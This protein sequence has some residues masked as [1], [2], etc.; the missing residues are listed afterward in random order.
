MLSISA[1]QLTCPG[2]VCVGRVF[3]WEGKGGG[4]IREGEG[5]WVGVQK[6]RMWEGGVCMS[7]GNECCAQN[8][9]FHCVLGA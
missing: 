9:V 6:G 8:Y 1:I 4:S 2:E 3:M 7:R 5:W